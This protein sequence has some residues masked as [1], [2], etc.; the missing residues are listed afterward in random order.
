MFFQPAHKRFEVIHHRAG[1]DVL[2]GGLLQDLAPVFSST[3]FKNV[4]Q[5]RADFLVIGVITRLRRLMQNL[6]SD[7]VVQLNFVE[8]ILRLE[9]SLN[10]RALQSQ[11]MHVLR[12]SAAAD[13]QIKMRRTYC[14]APALIR[15]PNFRGRDRCSPQR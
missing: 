12:S 8:R 6:A 9:L 14:P 7:V 13:D 11:H 15:L 5:P 1:G 2:A 10:S 3:F 4:V